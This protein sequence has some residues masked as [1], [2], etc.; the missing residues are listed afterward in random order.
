MLEAKEKM[1]TGDESI[2]GS[3]TWYDPPPPWENKASPHP[4]SVSISRLAD[5][6][7][8]SN[9]WRIADHYHYTA[10]CPV[11]YPILGQNNRVNL[12]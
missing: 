4:V 2:T 11:L 9:A 6:G 8:I 7:D 10:I 12:A 3:K 5:E 1:V